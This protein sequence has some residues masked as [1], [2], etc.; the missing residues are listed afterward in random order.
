MNKEL[1]NSGPQAIFRPPGHVAPVRDQTNK[2]HENGIFGISMWGSVR[3][4][5]I[6]HPFDENSFEPFC[7]EMSETQVPDRRSPFSRTLP[8]L[9]GPGGS[10]DRPPGAIFQLPNKWFLCLSLFDP[11]H[12][13]W[14][15]TQSACLRVCPARG[16]LNAIPMV[17][18]RQLMQA[19]CP[20]KHRA[21]VSCEIHGP[22][23]VLRTQDT[24]QREG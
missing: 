11:Q 16:S 15:V 10:N 17:H 21:L 1:L 24:P 7:L 12:G 4:D 9:W 18:S 6:C 20:L 19:V 2:T 3:K 23:A 22:A 14:C 13:P 8:P 5:I